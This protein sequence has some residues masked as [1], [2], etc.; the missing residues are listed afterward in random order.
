MR[1][2]IAL[3]AL[4]LLLVLCAFAACRTL[5]PAEVDGGT[6]QASK[7]V[8]IPLGE[9]IEFE[10]P[11]DGKNRDFFLRLPK[12][13]K[14][15][16]PV[17]TIFILH[18]GTGSADRMVHTSE[19]FFKLADRDNYILVFPEGIPD[20][21]GG[22]RHHWNDGRKDSRWAAHR[23]NADDVGF[24]SALID[25]VVADYGA[26]P[27][28]IYVTGASN[29]GMMTYR[30]GCELSHKIA[31]IAALI[32]NLPPDQAACQNTRPIPVLIINGDSD[33][34]MPYHGGEIRFGQI[35]LGKVLSTAETVEIWVRRNRITSTPENRLLPDLD[36]DDGT[37]VQHQVYGSNS[38]GVQ[39]ILYTVQN[40][41]HTW[42]GRGSRSGTERAG[43]TSQDISADQVIWD[44]FKKH[45]L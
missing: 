28:R 44:F 16:G 18:G 36:S 15:N 24:I 25:F 45:K 6:T 9:L 34:L 26:D 40:G 13:Y 43:K 2:R 23:Q 21:P 1:Y 41:G 35:K 11:Y 10:W 3:R 19:T 8:G 5:P 20:Q 42:P 29:G 38:S 37:R 39:V 7:T 4:F 17:P 12:G 33:P 14:G 31:A 30:L 27:S 22:Y 32:A